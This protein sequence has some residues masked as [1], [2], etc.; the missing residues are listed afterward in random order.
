MEEEQ[1]AMQRWLSDASGH[2]IQ[3]Y[4]QAAARTAPAELQASL[5]RFESGEP[6]G[7]E[8]E[9][10]PNAPAVHSP[11]GSAPATRTLF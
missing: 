7:G 11:R 3:A 8:D 5:A 6:L 1:A 10:G 2:S 9:G 4:R